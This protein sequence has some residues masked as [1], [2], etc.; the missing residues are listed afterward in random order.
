MHYMLP[1]ASAVVPIAAGVIFIFEFISGTMKGWALALQTFFHVVM[2]FAAVTTVPTIAAVPFAVY[3]AILHF[4][5][6]TLLPWHRVIS[7]Q[8]GYP[9]F[10]PLPERK[11]SAGSDAEEK[12]SPSV[13]KE[14][15][16]SEQKNV[17]EKK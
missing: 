15:D 13:K 1:R 17:D 11:K 7:E 9:E 2:I 5:L 3:G 14:E 12:E 10:T 16:A 4:K 8:P 6:I